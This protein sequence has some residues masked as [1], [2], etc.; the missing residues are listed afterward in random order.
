MLTTLDHLI[1][2]VDDLEA[3]TERFATM[4]GRRSSWCGGD[5]ALGAKNA[6]FRLSNTYLE[7]LQGVPDLERGLAG[8]VFG[9]DDIDAAVAELR[10]RGLDV[11]DPQPGEGKD[12][13]TG[14]VRHW[15]NA[16]FPIEQTRGVFSF[17]IQH[18]S[19]PDA[20]PL[21][22]PDGE[23]G[24][25]V[26]ALDH[27]VVNSAAPDASRAHYGDVLGLRLA[28]DRTFPERGVRLLFFRVGG[29]T[30][31][32]SGRS[33]AEVEPDAFDR[34]WGTAYQVGNAAAAH[35]RL[36]AA[37]FDL[38]ALRDGHK[39]GTRVFT[40]KDPPG[41]VPTLIIEPVAG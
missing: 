28:L 6:L 18:L 10:N 30:V 31:E 38:T 27:V 35:E 37:G 13:K 17:A 32:I 7:L 15:R 1:V 9:T 16:M 12:E 25:V 33:E 23:Q 22:A 39:P 21:V 29:T 14:A 4:L 20:L 34:L 36:E 8:I 3:E 19:E 41:G 40:V 24:A 5:P 11:S 26:G 2:S